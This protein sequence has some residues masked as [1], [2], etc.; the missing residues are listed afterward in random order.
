MPDT[1]S[2]PDVLDQIAETLGEAFALEVAARLGGTEIWLKADPGAED[3]VVQAL[4]MDKARRLA[5]ALGTGKLL[6]PMAAGADRARRHARI[7]SLR[8]AGRP[9]HEVARA[10]GV[11][12]RTVYRVQER[13][14]RK[15]PLFDRED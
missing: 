15:L 5:A 14:G 10:A 8:A 1:P 3:R 12:E 13:A 9:I 6:V 4:G 2:L 11:H 7:A